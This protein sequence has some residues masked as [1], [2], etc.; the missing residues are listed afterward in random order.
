[1]TPSEFAILREDISK[2]FDKAD[3]CAKT[4]VRIEQKV[5]THKE[6]IDDCNH[7]R[8]EQI[9]KNGEIDANFLRLKLTKEI[10]TQFNG[11]ERRKASITFDRIVRILTVTAITI[12][13]ILTLLLRFEIL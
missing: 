12:F 4:G 6:Y 11:D 5:D 13:G 2:L 8:I 9:K 10:K 1:M 3:D 7:F